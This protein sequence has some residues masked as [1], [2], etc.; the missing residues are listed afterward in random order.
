[1]SSNNGVTP[2]SIQ[3]GK[4]IL[5]IPTLA[6][7]GIPFGGYC[8]AVFNKSIEQ[9]RRANF[10]HSWVSRGELLV[11]YHLR[12]FQ[13]A[14][15]PF[16][17][18]ISDPI[19]THKVEITSPVSGLILNMRSEN[20]L[21]FGHGGLQY[22]GVDERVLPVLL[23]PED[24][25]LAETGPFYRYDEIAHQMLSGFDL[26]PIRDRSN[27]RPER[28]RDYI[29][30]GGSIAGSLSERLQV[31]RTRKSG[32]SRQYQ[33]RTLSKED[34]ETIYFVDELRKADIG[35][36]EKLVH[37]SREFGESI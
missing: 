17:P 34:R 20:T 18:L 30:R 32:G 28:I 12:F 13:K 25:P 6:E 36:R 15:K 19:W 22:E 7:V 3:F 23:V 8:R 37:I 24:E 27:I 1:M 35:L 10:G 11:T 26:I 16:L 14:N 29:Q 4:K 5:A 2:S 33:I 9:R 21:G 31:F